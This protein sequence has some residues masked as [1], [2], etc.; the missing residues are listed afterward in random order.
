MCKSVQCTTSRL[1]INT[2]T[3]EGTTILTTATAVAAVGVLGTV[4]AEGAIL[5]VLIMEVEAADLAEE[6]A[7]AEEAD[8]EAGSLG[9]PRTWS[10]AYRSWY[11]QS[12][13]VCLDSVEPQR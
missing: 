6:T 13:G 1:I 5:E 10:V 12:L 2:T 3:A 7:E 4:R 11:P 9:C 8:G